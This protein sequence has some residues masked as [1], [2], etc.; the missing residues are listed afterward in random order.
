MA[1]ILPKK[2]Q[3]LLAYLKQYIEDKGYAPTLTEI[4]D[5][6]EVS[7]LATIHEHLESLKKN[8]F[9][10]RDK[11][12]GRGIS[13][14]KDMRGNDSANGILLPVVGVIA[15]GEPIEALE[16]K[17]S[18][19]A[20]PDEIASNKDAYILKVRGDSMIESMVADGDYVIV[21]KTDYA[22]NGDMIVALLE[23]GTATLKKFFKQKNTIKLQPANK[24][25]KPLITPNVTVQG[26]V[27]GV[28]RRF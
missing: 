23:D 25:Y 2:K 21:E 18:N 15:A 17:D 27:L 6:F 13:I 7:S 24:K 10:S 1:K 9:I 14:I 22:K 28:I 8:G 4:A 3:A 11:N 16:D 20:V 12:R 19:I 26:K 5:H